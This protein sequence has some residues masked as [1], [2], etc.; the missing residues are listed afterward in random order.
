MAKGPGLRAVMA[1]GSGLNMVMKRF[2]KTNG[3]FFW[4]CLWKSMLPLLQLSNG[5]LPSSVRMKKN[6]GACKGFKKVKNS[7]FSLKFFAGLD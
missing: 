6:S 2:L 1:Q 4:K 5:E 7:G 3:M